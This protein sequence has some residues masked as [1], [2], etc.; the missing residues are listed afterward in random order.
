ML[1]YCT[2]TTVSYNL[3]S[4]AQGQQFARK[5]VA[6]KSIVAEKR[7]PRSRHKVG[8]ATPLSCSGVC[9]TVEFTRTLFR[10]VDQAALSNTRSRKKRGDRFVA[11]PARMR[12]SHG[13]ARGALYH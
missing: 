2:V 12:K 3:L 6:L 5:S 9:H 7:G 8:I 4:V 1:I 13:E 11:D 10:L